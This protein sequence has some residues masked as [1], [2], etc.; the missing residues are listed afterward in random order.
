M[1][2]GASN[3]FSS[4]TLNKKIWN[5]LIKSNFPK[6]PKEIAYGTQDMAN[7]ASKLVNEKNEYQLFSMEGHEEGVIFY[8][9]NPSQ[10]LDNVLKIYNKFCS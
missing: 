10:C 8:H 2:L 7:F 3:H 4:G 5:E 1:T 9:S 6:I